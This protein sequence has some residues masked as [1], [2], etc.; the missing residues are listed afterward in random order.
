M[1]GGFFFKI[2]KHD[3]TFIREMRVTDLYY[4]RLYE[5]FLPPVQFTD[6]KLLHCKLGR[7]RASRPV[8][9]VWE[10]SNVRIPDFRFFSLPDSGLIRVL[11]MEKSL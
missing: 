9:V 2:N 6:C 11:E 5:N 8:P 7:N 10:F 4:E 3:S 1:E